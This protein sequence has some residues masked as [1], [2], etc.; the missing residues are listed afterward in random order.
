MTRSRFGLLLCS[1]LATITLTAG[2]AMAISHASKFSAPL[3]DPFV[4]CGDDTSTTNCNGTYATLSPWVYDQGTVEIGAGS[5]GLRLDNIRLRNGYQCSDV[6]GG[7]SAC[8]C[9]GDINLNYCST[10]ASCAE[11][12]GP[13]SAAGSD[14]DYFKV[15]IWAQTTHPGGV[16]CGS[17]GLCPHIERAACHKVVNF[18]LK[19][20]SGNRN[21]DV[22]QSV[23][24]SWGDCLDSV[25]DPEIRRVEVYDKWGNIVGVVSFD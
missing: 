13:S 24:L 16:L 14:N 18:D 8:R 20:V 9:W 23:S 6:G 10:H 19:N 4:E 12:C 3:T 25:A 7:A 2:P 11:M 1:A 21:E 5:V 17:G 22:D 15:E